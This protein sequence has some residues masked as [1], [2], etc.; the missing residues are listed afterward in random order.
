[1]VAECILSPESQDTEVEV[2]ASYNVPDGRSNS[3]TQLNEVIRV[4]RDGQVIE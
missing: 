3:R 1:M 4:I 2:F